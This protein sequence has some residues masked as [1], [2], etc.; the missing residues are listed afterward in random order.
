MSVDSAY[1][2]VRHLR[3]DPD[4]QRRLRADDADVERLCA[5]ATALGYEAEPDD[6]RLAFR[7]EWG[8]RWLSAGVRTPES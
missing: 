7:S 1:A 6:L 2:F 8:L 4:L 3:S 5:E